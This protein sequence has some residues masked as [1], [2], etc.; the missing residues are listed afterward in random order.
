M[1]KLLFYPLLACTLACPIHAETTPLEL[2]IHDQMEKVS[3]QAGN[4]LKSLISDMQEVYERENFEE[5]LLATLDHQVENPIFSSYE[6]EAPEA[7]ASARQAK[8]L[9]LFCAI[10][11]SQLYYHWEILGEPER[12]IHHLARILSTSRVQRELQAR[13]CPMLLA[14]IEAPE[15]RDGTLQLLR[16]QYGEAAAAAFEQWDQ[17]WDSDEKAKDQSLPINYAELLDALRALYQDYQ[18]VIP[19]LKEKNERLIM[20]REMRSLAFWIFLAKQ[21]GELTLSDEDARLLFTC[22]RDL[23]PAGLTRVAKAASNNYGEPSAASNS[24]HQ[25]Y[26]LMPQQWLERGLSDWETTKKQWIAELD[27]LYPERK[28]YSKE[29]WK[30]I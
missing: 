27:R 5:L 15:D 3:Q 14:F 13:L 28:Q 10:A 16:T 17:E 30:E 11:S 6:K 7:S 24:K 9:P 18:A 20:T 22:V 23:T 8:M 4:K 1:S 19:Q 21:S 25:P 29:Q 26:I 2:T 12:R